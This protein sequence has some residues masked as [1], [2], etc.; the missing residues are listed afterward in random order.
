MKTHRFEVRVLML[1]ADN[2]WLAMS[3]D[4]QAEAVSYAVE[5]R[6]RSKWSRNVVSVYDTKTMEAL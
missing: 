4:S 6:T 2:Y 1:K 5:L 3:T